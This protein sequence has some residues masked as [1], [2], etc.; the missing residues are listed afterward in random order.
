MSMNLADEE[1]N[2]YL[3]DQEMDCAKSDNVI[4][5]LESFIKADT[6]GLSN[7]SHISFGGTYVDSFS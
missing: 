4:T 3:C 2:D 1:R 7:L 5:Q 6:D